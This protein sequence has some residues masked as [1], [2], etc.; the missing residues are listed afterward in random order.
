MLLT[1]TE[2]EAGRSAMYLFNTD[3]A[4]TEAAVQSYL[5]PTV[6]PSSNDNQGEE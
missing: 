6:T 4:T 1:A 5:T 2:A 3:V